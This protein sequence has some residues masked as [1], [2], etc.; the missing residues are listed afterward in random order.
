MNDFTYVQLEVAMKRRMQA[1]PARMRPYSLGLNA[2]PRALV[3]T[4]QRGVGKTTCLLHHARGKRF[5]YLSV[6]SPL[7]ANA[8][9]YETV[10]GLFMK[11][12]EGVIVDEVHFAKDWSLHAKALYD[13]FPD[14]S[15]WLSDSSALILRTG[16]ADLSRRYV[17][18]AM[19]LMSFREFLC[20]RTGRDWPVFDPFV[21]V[22]LAGDAEI[23]SQFQVYRRTGTRPFF[24][25]GHFRERMLGIMEK[26]MQADIPFFLPQITDGNLRLLN[27]IV[28]TLAQSTIPR[29]QVR[30]LCADWH[31]GAEKLYQLVFIMESVGLLR[32]VRKAHDTKANTV[33]DKLFFGDPVYYDIL[34]G[35]SGTAREALVAAM[36]AEA[37]HSVASSGDETKADFVINDRLVLEVG[38]ASKRPKQAD[39]VIRDDIDQAIGKAIPLWALGFGY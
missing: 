13:D 12:F 6:D 37:G 28:G 33:G 17:S 16:R 38:G 14:R 9:L 26:T 34:G 27:A 24:A 4:G 22:P 23:L 3:L 15:L 8:S 20:L 19:P 7:L 25:E 21:T 39:F 5:M 36:L 18:I 11:G 30:S 31:I 1:M 32:I 35:D 10:H 29:L 2:L